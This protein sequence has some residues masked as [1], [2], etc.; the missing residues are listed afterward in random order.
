MSGNID[1]ATTST[2]TAKLRNVEIKCI[3][4]VGY[5]NCVPLLHS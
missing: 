4:K 3:Y 5:S 1:L 2:A